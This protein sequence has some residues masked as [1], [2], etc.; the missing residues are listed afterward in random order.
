MKRIAWGIL[1]A[2]GPVLTAGL[3]ALMV[4]IYGRSAFAELLQWGLPLLLLSIPLGAALVV[5]GAV[6]ML[7]EYRA[8][9]AA[10]ITDRRI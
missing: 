2:L 10:G 6:R 7:A 5:S 1:I 8:R 9:R 4:K 3:G